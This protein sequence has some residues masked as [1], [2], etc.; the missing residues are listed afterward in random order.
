MIEGGCLCGAVRYK[1]DKP[2]L[3]Q[4]VCHCTHCQRQSGS[5]FSVLLA[6]RASALTL[7]GQP[8]LYE[9]Q[10]DSGARVHR[11]FCARCGSPIYTALPASPKVVFIKAGTL[12]D[13]SAMAPQ[14]HVWCD[15]AW[16]WTVFP[17]GAEK[18][19]KNPA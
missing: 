18:I 3:G 7:V 12:D 1:S 16:P 5:A 13:T 11:Y 4:A 8:A 17:E 6:V 2:A 19:A 10:G 15:S 9:D 14:T